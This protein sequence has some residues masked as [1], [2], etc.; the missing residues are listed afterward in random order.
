[1]K[2]KKDFHSFVQNW[3]AIKKGFPSMTVRQSV[4]IGIY[5]ILSCASASGGE[6]VIS[7][8]YMGKN[9][10]FQNPLCGPTSSFST[11]SVYVNGILK[12]TNPTTSAFEV[13]LSNLAINSAIEIKLIYN[14]NCSPEI[15]NPQVIRPKHSFYFQKFN[16]AEDSISWITNGESG[17]HK[18]M[19]EKRENNTWIIFKSCDGNGNQENRYSLNVTHNTGE[20]QYRIKYISGEGKIFYSGILAFN[21]DKEPVTFYPQRVTNKITLS[22]IA[23]Y[24][25]VDTQGNILFKGKDKEIMLKNLNP[26]LYYLVVDN[27]TEKFIK[28]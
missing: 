25:I 1:L 23:A 7:G 13:D 16:V 26:G 6:L 17:I 28:K 9:V 20:N 5:F 4:F 15:I 19:I 21:N 3:R 8:V 11:R 12:V 2:N 27:R 24:Q 18:F 14:E 10:Y 22:R